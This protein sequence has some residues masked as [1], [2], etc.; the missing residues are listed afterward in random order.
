MFGPNIGAVAFSPLSDHI[1]SDLPV[2]VLQ[3]DSV[4]DCV[5]F[6]Q[7]PILPVQVT[8]PSLPP[9]PLEYLTN[10]IISIIPVA[11]ITKKITNTATTT[12][13]PEPTSS[14]PLANTQTTDFPAPPSHVLGGSRQQRDKLPAWS[15]TQDQ[16][17][18]AAGAAG[19]NVSRASSPTSQDPMTQVTTA[20][21]AVD[22]P[23]RPPV[24][25]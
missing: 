8:T 5:N 19:L 4:D 14:Q 17:V 9:V 24:V 6:R 18:A 15:V 1:T 20:L 22:A 2:N 3:A 23:V 21:S 12:L 13:S 7:D 16:V 25:M 10:G 11:P